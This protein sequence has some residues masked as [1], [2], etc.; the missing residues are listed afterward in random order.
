[1]MGF[2]LSHGM[3]FGSTAQPSV[4]FLRIF[5]TDGTRQT[6]FC[7]EGTGILASR[8]KIKV[9]IRLQYLSG[10][11][12]KHKFHHYLSVRPDFPW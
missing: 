10:L 3:R 5:M 9:I 7:R 12:L 4:H 11:L 1:M 8:Q 6:Q 2:T